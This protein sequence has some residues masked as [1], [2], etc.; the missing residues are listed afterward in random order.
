MTAEAA[1]ARL[2]NT[3]MA[4][5]DAPVEPSHSL[6]AA[7]RVVARVKTLGKPVPLPVQ[8]FMDRMSDPKAPNGVLDKLSRD[9][10]GSDY[11]SLP[12]DKQTGVYDIAH[13]LRNHNHATGHRYLKAGIDFAQAKHILISTYKEVGSMKADYPQDV[14]HGL[15]DFA[16][17][18]EKDLDEAAKRGGFYDE[19]SRTQAELRDAIKN[20]MRGA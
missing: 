10:H 6:P 1:R 11:K 14:R 4:H 5:Y 3:T 19:Y 13:E 15:N 20:R 8:R 9:L 16:A 18:L 2:E 12:E 7:E 17:G